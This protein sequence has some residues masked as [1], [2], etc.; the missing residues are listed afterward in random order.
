MRVTSKRLVLA[1][2]AAALT[3]MLL[4][5]G[6]A[7]AAF[8]R[9]YLRS[10]PGTATRLFTGPFQTEPG[11]FGVAVDAQNNLWVSEYH[12]NPSKSAL[13]PPFELDEF[14][15]PSDAFA[16]TLDIEGLNP[17]ESEYHEPLGLT[18]PES[19]MVDWANGDFYTDGK[20]T[21]LKP[22]PGYV[23]VF[24]NSGTYVTRFRPPSVGA[25]GG[26]K[27]I[28][29]STNPFDPSAGSLYAVVMV[30]SSGASAHPAV[31]KLNAAGEPADFVN[32]FGQPTKLPYVEGSTIVGSPTSLSGCSEPTF[33]SNQP[34]AVPAIT[35]D[36]QGDIYV[37]SECRQGGGSKG[38]ADAV[39]EYRPSGE[40]VRSYFGEETPGIGDGREAH[41]NG[42]FGGSAYSPNAALAFDPVSNHLLI[43]LYLQNGFGEGENYE[44][45][46]DEFDAATGKFVAQIADAGE[47]EA[48]RRPSQMAVD[49][50]GD[51][52]VSEPGRHVVAA[53][54]P[55]RFLAGERLGE[56][57]GRTSSSA[58]LNGSVDPEGLGVSQC[59]FQ[60]VPASI[61]DESGFSNAG[62]V[63][64][65]PC[66]PAP[67]AIQPTSSYQPVHASVSSL[68][69]GTTYRYRLLVTTEGPLGGASASSSLAFR[70]PGAPRV[71]SQLAEGV[72]SSFVALRAS[73]AP[74][75][76]QTSYELEYCR[77]SRVRAGSGRSLCGGRCRTRAG[78]RHRR[79][80]SG[81]RRGRD[82]G[83]ARGRLDAGHDVPFQG[84]GVQRSRRDVR[85]RRDVHDVARAGLRLARRS[86]L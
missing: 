46:I 24:D 6:P 43:A 9:P 84:R 45:V 82:R 10:I 71:Q 52:Y 66:V 68:V 11:P 75:G 70:A 38:S 57:T 53:Y 27:A 59:E 50:E 3:A 56:A 16:R 34:S 36:P 41:E 63:R 54:G 42:G 78:G 13:E 85:R 49:S 48:L 67:G 86:V 64:E 30:G 14:E 21:S 17:P 39:L 62:A 65:A 25:G 60:Y 40:F 61:F 7:W 33:P 8:T 77:R 29:N 76:A 35:V 4:G 15:Y 69:S 1:A 31:I 81:G 55:G 80:R 23:E 18:P 28:D 58:V 37:M 26:L 72:S 32:E 74:E 5:A 20:V 2:V 83:A 51:L 19:L 12:S 47:G 44:G 22:F 79:G 73:I